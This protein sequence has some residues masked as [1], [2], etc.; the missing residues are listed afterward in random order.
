M[1]GA[2]RPGPD[3]GDLAR[4][5]LELTLGEQVAGLHEVPSGSAAL[6]ARYLLWAESAADLEALLSPDLE[7]ALLA[8]QGPSSPAF[9]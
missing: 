9:A 4:R 3:L 2:R 8:W 5:A 1:V 6:R 7:A